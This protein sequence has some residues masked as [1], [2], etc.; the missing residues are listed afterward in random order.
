MASNGQSNEKAESAS[1]KALQVLLFYVTKILLQR[2][3][4]RHKSSSIYSHHLG[5]W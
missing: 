3:L 4:R 2:K 5:K 1:G